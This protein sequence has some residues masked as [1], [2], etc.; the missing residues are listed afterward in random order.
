MV[1][2]TALLLAL[3]VLYYVTVDKEPVPDF[4]YK[5]P[6]IITVEELPPIRED[7]K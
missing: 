5:E 1:R 6:S 7:N 4:T 3:V 2:L